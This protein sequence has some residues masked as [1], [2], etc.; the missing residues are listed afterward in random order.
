LFTAHGFDPAHLLTDE[1]DGYFAFP[2][3]CSSR[4]D[5]VDCIADDAGL[6]DKEAALRHSVDTWWEGRSGGIA[7]LE[8]SQRVMQLRADLLSSFEDAV[9]P[10]GL[11]DRFEVTGVIASWWGENQ[12]DL[13]TIAARGCLGLVCAWESSILSALEDRESSDKNVKKLASKEDPLNHKLIRQILPEHL[14]QISELQAEKAELESQLKPAPDADDAEQVDTED[15]GPELSADEVKGVKKQLTNVRKQ[16]NALQKEFVERLRGAIAGLD[17]APAQDLVLAI[18]Q[19]DLHAIID[20]HVSRHRRLVVGAFEIWWDKYR[21]TLA[22][23]EDD[24]DAASHR[25]HDYLLEL[26]YG[27]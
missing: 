10:I 20:R 15:N 18:L 25:L 23:L 4:S 22:A 6:S 7:G 16:L 12:M 26:G 14:E 5:L 11:L 21:L 13:K 9:R 19:V 17:E 1:G 24:R 2:E 27:G 3:I 8:T